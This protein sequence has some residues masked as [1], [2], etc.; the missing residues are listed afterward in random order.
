MYDEFNYGWVAGKAAFCGWNFVV[1]GKYE[2]KSLCCSVEIFFYFYYFFQ[3]KCL[4]LYFFRHIKY[5]RKNHYQLIIALENRLYKLHNG[6]S[7]ELESRIN[8]KPFPSVSGV[9][10]NYRYHKPPSASFSPRKR[11]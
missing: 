1:V 8:T 6:I 10:S 9:E 4:V 5:V 2:V 7:Q 11:G 3:K